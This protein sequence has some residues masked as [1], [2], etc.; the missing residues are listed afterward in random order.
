MRTASSRHGQTAFEIRIRS[1]REKAAGHELE[2]DPIGLREKLTN[3]E[4]RSDSH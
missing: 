4:E 2:V 3:P 1:F